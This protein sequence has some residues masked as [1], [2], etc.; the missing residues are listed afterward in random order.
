MVWCDLNDRCV[1]LLKTGQ[2][3]SFC[4]LIW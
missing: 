4:E 2:N 3:H 1:K